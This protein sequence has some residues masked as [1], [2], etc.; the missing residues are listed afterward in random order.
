[1]RSV[2]LGGLT[3]RSARREHPLANEL[4]A[5]GKEI[6]NLG[7][8]GCGHLALEVS[9]KLMNAEIWV[10][11]ADPTL[12]I[13]DP[14][15]SDRTHGPVAHATCKH[16]GFFLDCNGSYQR[17]Q[18]TKHEIPHGYRLYVKSVRPDVMRAWLNHRRL[19]N[20]AFDRRKLPKLRRLVRERIS[21]F[22]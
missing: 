19:W 21:P 3:E 7:Y 5:I 15:W 13:S 6:P 14:D 10:I 12:D 2:E 22:A 1:M 18:E 17:I 4:K 8:G 20:S 9:T 16:N 11:T